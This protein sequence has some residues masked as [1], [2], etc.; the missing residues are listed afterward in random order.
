MKKSRLCPRKRSRNKAS[1]MSGPSDLAVASCRSVI[2]VKQAFFLLKQQQQQ[3]QQQQLLLLLLLL[4]LLYYYRKVK[5]SVQAQ[6]NISNGNVE[7]G[8]IHHG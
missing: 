3:Q 4:L 7:S 5:I 6:R 1:L 2:K 8:L